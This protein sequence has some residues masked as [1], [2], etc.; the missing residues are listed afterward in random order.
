MHQFVEDEPCDH[1]VS[2]QKCYLRRI[3]L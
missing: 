1:L 3:C 2:I